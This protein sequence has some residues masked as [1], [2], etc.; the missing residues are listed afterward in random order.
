MDTHFICCRH[1]VLSSILNLPK[2]RESIRYCT[3]S[4]CA[5]RSRQRTPQSMDCMMCRP[6]AKRDKPRLLC[7]WLAARHEMCLL[8]KA[9][10]PPRKGDDAMM[11]HTV[12]SMHLCTEAVRDGLHAWAVRGALRRRSSIRPYAQCTR[13]LRSDHLRL[14]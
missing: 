4:A 8:H 12:L 14:V 2:G 5:T 13:T 7:V 11:T 9:L 10:L 3:V 1:I 6:S